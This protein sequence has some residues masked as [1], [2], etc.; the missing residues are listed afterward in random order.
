MFPVSAGNWVHPGEFASSGKD[1]FLLLFYFKSQAFLMM[2]VTSH[3]S[4]ICFVTVG[5]LEIVAGCISFIFHF[6]VSSVFF[7][8]YIL[9]GCTQIF[10][11]CIWR[12]HVLF[13]KWGFYKKIILKIP[14]RNWKTKLKRWMWRGKVI[15]SRF[16]SLFL[17]F[18][19]LLHVTFHSPI[20]YFGLFTFVLFCPGWFLEE[21]CVICDAY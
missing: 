20:N 5:G 1:Y 17:T 2:I 15:E 16:F 21:K 7:S 12:I 4:T 9:I 19:L 14:S 3:H 18:H 10:F 6:S 13:S 11:C 8:I